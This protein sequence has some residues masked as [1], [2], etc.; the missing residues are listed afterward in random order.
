[1]TRSKAPFRRKNTKKTLISQV[2][3]EEQS[4]VS[5]PRTQQSWAPTQH[6][7]GFR[8]KGKNRKGSQRPAHVRT[9]QTMHTTRENE[10]PKSNLLPKETEA[11]TINSPRHA[12]LPAKKQRF[13]W[14]VLLPWGRAQLAEHLL[15]VR[16][17]LSSIPGN[18]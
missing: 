12:N 16:K 11:G 1:M 6:G 2:V 15:R 10:K 17:D 9:I 7:W 13:T 5:G 3:Y 18:G 14:K 4:E 8:I